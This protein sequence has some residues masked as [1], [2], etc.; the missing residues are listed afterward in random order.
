LKEEDICA[1]ELLLVQKNVPAPI[2]VIKFWRSI[3]QVQFISSI[4]V[5]L[6]D[7]LFGVVKVKIQIVP[8]HAMAVGGGEWKQLHRLLDTALKG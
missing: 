1:K 2:P 7:W 6:E 3:P 5:V 4:H 8:V